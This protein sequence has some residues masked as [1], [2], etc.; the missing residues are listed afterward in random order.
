MHAYSLHTYGK[1]GQQYQSTLSN[2]DQSIAAVHTDT[3]GKYPTLP[4][5]R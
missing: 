2:L 5:V 1:T 3:T 4:V